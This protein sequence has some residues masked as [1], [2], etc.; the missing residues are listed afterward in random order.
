MQPRFEH[1]FSRVRVHAD[2]QAGESARAV[3][4]LAYTVGRNIVFGDGQYSPGTSNGQMLLAHELTHVV[5]QRSSADM[6]TSEEISLGPADS[7]QEGEAESAS[8]NFGSTSA[9]TAT[10]QVQR[11]TWDT[12]PVYEER[13]EIIAQGNGKKEPAKPEEKAAKCPTQTVTMSG[14]LCGNKYGAVGG[15]CYGNEAKNWWFKEKVKNGPGPLCQ[16]GNIDQTTNPFQSA[17]GCVKDDIF[18]NNGPPSKVAPCTD[19]TF[20]TVFAG[21]TKADVEKCQYKNTQVITVTAA[22]DGKSGKVKTSS[23]GVSTECDWP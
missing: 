6:P 10:H 23:A 14:A 21:P 20:Q 16:P 4:A 13:P 18:D 11:R 1:D 17:S 22:K 9:L 15:Y 12:L 3:E 5:Q 19:T 2:S 7:L 8:K